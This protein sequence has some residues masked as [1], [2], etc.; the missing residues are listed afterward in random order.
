METETTKALERWFR[1]NG[2]YLHPDVATSYSPAQGVHWRAR[3]AIGSATTVSNV[4]HSLA[5]SYLNALVDDAHPVFKQRQKAFGGVENIGF[6]YLMTQYIHKDT[7]FWRPYLECLPQPTSY[8][9]SPLWFD[10]N[11]DLA[12]L[13]GTDVLHTILGRKA[14]YEQYYNAGVSILNQAG[15]DTEPY[16]W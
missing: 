2:G 8:F 4:P 5:L 11:E 10:A 7:S 12:W 16:T 1:D 15:V 13:E 3:A 9:T 6:F 14:T